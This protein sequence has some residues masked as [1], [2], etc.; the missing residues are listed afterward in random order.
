[1]AIITG[2]IMPKRH[3]M[4]DCSPEASKTDRQGIYIELERAYDVGEID[5]STFIK[6]LRVEVTGLTREKMAIACK[7]SVRSLANL[8]TNKGNP[9]LSSLTAVLKPFGYRIGP[10][11]II[12]NEP[13]RGK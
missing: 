8:E 3:K 11:K 2:N 6:R 9:T 10:T 5:L 4:T 7:I 13:W 1:M 12:K